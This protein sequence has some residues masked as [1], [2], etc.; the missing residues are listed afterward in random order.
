MY[1]RRSTCEDLNQSLVLRSTSCWEWW[2]LHLDRILDRWVFEFEKMMK[3]SLSVFVCR[4]STWKLLNSSSSWSEAQLV[5]AVLWGT[6][7][8]TQHLNAFLWECVCVSLSLRY[9]SWQTVH[10][11]L[12]LPFETVW[13]CSHI[14][15]LNQGEC[16]Q[17]ASD[18][19]FFTFVG[20][21][22]WNCKG[23]FYYSFD[24]WYSCTLSLQSYFY[25]DDAFNFN[26]AQ[27]KAALGC[28]Q[29]AEEVGIS[30]MMAMWNLMT[31][32]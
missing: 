26:Y 14:S 7:W 31:W 9:H 12:L 30:F 21:I 1:D 18:D 2:M 13:R 29:E 16:S 15:Q 19:V 23:N 22:W 6:F 17:Q 28:Y 25:N 20:L 27:A 8:I 11:L 3:E 32:S 5:N 24:S 4:G 10:G